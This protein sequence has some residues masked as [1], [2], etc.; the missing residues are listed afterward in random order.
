M[1]RTL[2]NKTFEPNLEVRYT[3]YLRHEFYCSDESFRSLRRPIL[4]YPGKLFR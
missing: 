3:N 4:C 1:V 2:E